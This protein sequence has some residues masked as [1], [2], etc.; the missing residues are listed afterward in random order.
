[1]GYYNIYIMNYETHSLTG[2][3]VDVMSSNAFMPLITRP[4]RVTATSAT[5]IDNIFTNNF[6]NF[7]D[8][9]QGI[10]VTDISDHYPVFYIN[11]VNKLSEV[12]MFVE[13]RIYND[14]NK[15]AFFSELQNIDW[16][17]L[18][19]SS[20]TQSSFDLLHNQ[21][22]ALHNKHFPKVRKKIR[23]N[24]KKPWLSEGL[25]NSIKHKN[26]YYYKYQKII[27]LEMNYSVRLLKLG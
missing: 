14:K 21:L 16:S 7:R 3:F 18:C 8:S 13:N 23:Y 27:V 19:N 6:Q 4:T 1:M 22:S 20:E 15:Q 2:E 25:R 12:E 10:L 11:R 5:L 17:E 26:K 24:N 9:F